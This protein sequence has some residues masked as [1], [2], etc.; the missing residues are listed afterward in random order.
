MSLDH[1][2]TPSSSGL[3]LPL[4]DQESALR[5]NIN[6][7]T[8]SFSTEQIDVSEE[9]KNTSAWSKLLNLKGEED[10]N[11]GI[12]RKWSEQNFQ[13]W[14]KWSYKSK[15]CL[16]LNWGWIDGCRTGRLHN[17]TDGGYVNINAR[18]KLLRQHP[19]MSVL[20]GTHWRLLCG[21]LRRWANIVRSVPPSSDGRD[22]RQGNRKNISTSAMSL[23]R[24][25]EIYCPQIPSW[26]ESQRSY[27]VR[28]PKSSPWNTSSGRWRNIRRGRHWTRTW[29]A[30]GESQYHHPAV[31]IRHGALHYRTKMTTLKPTGVA[32]S[33]TTSLVTVIIAT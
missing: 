31:Q 3:M 9:N 2:S 28:Q 27:D 12:H 1:L 25:L 5:K 19:V 8:A 24:W 16:G 4:D 22:F 6:M 26:H 11:A 13:R 17:R 30:L 23:T 32:L 10:G 15:C 33:T 7:D 18:G 20:Q 21:S 14:L 29:S